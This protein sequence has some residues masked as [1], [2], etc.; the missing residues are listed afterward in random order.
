M[1]YHLTLCKCCSHLI[2]C[3]CF[4]L[5]CLLLTCKFGNIVIIYVHFLTHY[6][7][8]SQWHGNYNDNLIVKK[9]ECLEILNTEK[10]FNRYRICFN[11]LQLISES[12]RKC[13]RDFYLNR[14]DYRKKRKFHF[15]FY[16]LRRIIFISSIG[17]TKVSSLSTINR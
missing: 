2:R 14:S 10:K 5:D 15:L 7:W 16:K 8:G 6:V 4:A 1:S 11:T 3:N 13:F 12:L 17:F 9:S